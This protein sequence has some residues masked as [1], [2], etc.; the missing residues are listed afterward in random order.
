MEK[1]DENIIF[2]KLQSNIDDFKK[3]ELLERL[4]FI[5]ACTCDPKNKDIYEGLLHINQNNYKVTNKIINLPSLNDIEIKI[6]EK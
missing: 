5:A 1:F 3:K 4:K 2:K 6:N